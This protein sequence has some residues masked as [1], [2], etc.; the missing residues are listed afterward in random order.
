MSRATV[1]VRLIVIGL[2]AFHAGLLLHSLRQNFVVVEEVA[3]LAAGI[4]H[5]ETGT[6]SM[7][8][9]NPPLPRRLAVFPVLLAE[10]DT[11]GIYPLDVPGG[12]DEWI[13]G[14]RFAADNAGRYFDLVCLA[15]LSTVAWSLLGGWL[16][17]RWAS[18]L[19]G[20]AAGCLGLALWCFEPT[21][22]AHAQFT[23]P[24][25]PAAVAALAATYVFWR[26]LQKPSWGRASLA[27][28]LLGVAQLTKFTLLVLYGV[29]PLLWLMHRLG[30]HDPTGR[31]RL[32]TQAGQG[33]L[34]VALSLFVLNLGYEF[35]QTGRPL[36]EIPFVSRAFA[37][38]P[39]ER[40]TS[41]MPGRAGNRFRDTWLGRVP[42][43]LPADYIRGIDVQRCDFEEL[44]KRAGSYLAGE[45]RE[46]GWWYYYLYALAV[47]VPLGILALAL[48]ALGLTLC[49]RSGR[50]RRGGEW[51]LWL[52]A[53]GIL[54][55]VSS[56]TGFNHHMRY[57]LPFLPFVIV[58]T[59][60]LGCFFRPE[61]WKAGALVAVLLLWAAGSSLAI[62]PHYLSY[63]NELGGGPDNGH[64]HLLESNTDNGQDLLFLKGWLER[65]PEARPL[66]LAYYG[67]VD[68]RL[69][70]IAF[71]LPPSDPCP[72]Y[73]AV[74]INYVR[75]SC[76][77][78][79]PDGR[80]GWDHLPRDRYAYF[81]HFQP[82]A[83]A[84]YSLFVYH[85]TLGEA[86][87][88][89]Q[90]LGLPPLTCPSHSRGQQP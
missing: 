7:Y 42:V 84:G 89:R 34:I 22:L 28:L 11:D 26:Y 49:R 41:G 69:V 58:G 46:E 73:Y 53:L 67:A 62:H 18:E 61:R 86:N 33:L 64:D 12:R 51:A 85:I 75:G 71:T 47:K 68:P 52:P 19:Y 78:P 65:H 76:L 43:L 9:V 82:I 35:D 2:L 48:W 23:M 80:G 6:H 20:S 87:R 16:V 24:D 21:I 3:H 56:Q 1:A 36:G 70:G 88:A 4:S 17:Y 59:S 81:R 74:S 66:G 38:E 79:P 63:F 44:G 13:N 45:W 57:V 5:W 14:E 54:A 72:G 31:V 50:D 15:R 27:G 40:E 60:K 8:R 55:L 37:G 29:W 83:K 10:P 32:G 25:L 39:A 90:Q 77:V 30:R